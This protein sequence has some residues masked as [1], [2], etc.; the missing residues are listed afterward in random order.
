MR[1][2]L[3]WKPIGLIPRQVDTINQ[4]RGKDGH[5]QTILVRDLYGH[6]EGRKVL[7]TSILFLGAEVFL[8]WMKLTLGF[9]SVNKV[10]N[11]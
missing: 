7:N 2:K 8:T 6:V 11:C 9:Y 1:T 3:W 10:I 4:L 5:Q